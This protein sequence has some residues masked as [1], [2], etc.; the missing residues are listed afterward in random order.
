MRARR[1]PDIASLIRA[2]KLLSFTCGAASRFVRPG[3]GRRPGGCRRSAIAGLGQLIFQPLLLRA[4]EHGAAARRRQIV[5]GGIGGWAAGAGRRTLR[6]SAHG[7]RR[8]VG[9]GA[10]AAR[11]H[12]R[13]GNEQCG[14]KA[15]CA[16][17]GFKPRS[18]NGAPAAGLCPCR[19]CRDTRSPKFRSALL[20]DAGSRLDAGSPA[21]LARS[22]C[23]Y[24]QAE[25]G[26]N[27]ADYR[28]RA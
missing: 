17:A 9:N 4:A 12:H 5:Y 28:L 15:R 6:Q 24:M 13:T 21:P 22:R 26:A 16:G 14:E 2:T 11:D 1:S 10:G 19:L 7:R 23:L 8:A 3:G 20:V 27:P 25:N 18:R